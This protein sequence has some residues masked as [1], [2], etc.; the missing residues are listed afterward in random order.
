MHPFSSAQVRQF[1]DT[2][3]RQTFAGD[4]TVYDE[5]KI[6]YDIE[7][8][9][10]NV[11]DGPVKVET[12]LGANRM[13]IGKHGDVEISDPHAGRNYVKVE[14]DRNKATLDVYVPLSVLDGKPV[15]A[16]RQIALT[17][18]TVAKTA[19]QAGDPSGVWET[20]GTVPFAT[21]SYADGAWQVNNDQAQL[22]PPQVSTTLIAS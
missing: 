3:T 2:H 21:L 18:Q 1:V 20:T 15:E 12:T 16:D 4:P 10:Q 13:Q 14:V 8:E 17:A 6:K 9:P 19:A 11:E 22:P 7:G 5:L